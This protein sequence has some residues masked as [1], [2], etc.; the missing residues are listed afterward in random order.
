MIYNTNMSY[1]RFD[2]AAITGQ[3]DRYNLHT[4]TQFCDGRS[5]IMEMARDACDSGM[6]YL[7]FTPHS[8]VNVDS[9]CNMSLTD[10]DTYAHAIDEA[11]KAFPSL[12]IYKGMEIDYLGSDSGPSSPIVKTWS[13]DYCIG[14]VHFVPTRSG[15]MIDIDGSPERFARNLSQ[16]FDKDLRY[17]VETFYDQS[18]A[19]VRAGGMDIV[20]HLDKVHANASSVDR[21]ITEYPWYRQRVMALI[22]LIAQ[23]GVAV[24]INT[25]AFESGGVIFPMTEYWEELIRR[26]IPVVVNS[27]AHEVGRIDSGRSRALAMLGEINKVFQNKSGNM[28]GVSFD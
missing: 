1:R 21:H 3:T 7:G 4:H 10:V 12:T 8:P 23:T 22:D 17:V 9:P 24:E 20:G 13:L 15:V 14:S 6:L 2:I 25:K 11:R 26:S 5:S 28:S 27:D 16:C 19:M 18:M